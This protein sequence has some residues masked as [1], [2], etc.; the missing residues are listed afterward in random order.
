MGLVQLTVIINLIAN[1]VDGLAESNIA[2]QH[3]AS[4]M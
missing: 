3:R 4:I 2:C 1:A